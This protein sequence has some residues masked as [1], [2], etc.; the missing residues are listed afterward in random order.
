VTFEE[1]NAE[2][3]LLIGERV[4]FVR[5]VCNSII[6]YFRGD[7][8][9]SAVVSVFIDPT[10]RLQHHGKV[11][12]GSYDLQIDEGDF[13]S[14]KEYQEEYERI[15]ALTDGLEG[16]PLEAVEINLESSDLLMKFSDQRVVRNFANSGFDDKAWTYRNVAQ[17]IAVVVSSL[18]IE[19]RSTKD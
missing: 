2:L 8:G 3:Q 4:S 18:G 19:E 9:D 13:E 16:S 12:V 1:L 6:I 17:G 5:I 7:P 14:K 15:V 10:W 11:V